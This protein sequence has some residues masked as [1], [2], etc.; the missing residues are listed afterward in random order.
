MV[1]K[2]LYQFMLIIP[3]FSQKIKQIKTLRKIF[4]L[5]CSLNIKHLFGSIDKAKLLFYN[6]YT[7]N[8]TLVRYAAF[9]PAFKEVERIETND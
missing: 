6:V 2:L 5:R 9:L 8:R 7:R 1:Q 3:P 4:T